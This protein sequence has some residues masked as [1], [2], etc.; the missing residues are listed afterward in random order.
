MVSVHLIVD[1]DIIP[2]P[3]VYYLQMIIRVVYVYAQ[4][5]QA[6]EGMVTRGR[7]M[8]NDFVPLASFPF[9]P[10]PFSPESITDPENVS[11][12]RSETTT[13]TPWH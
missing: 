12:E 9:Y 7:W 11:K 1:T 2:R 6:A 8:N 3:R 4:N 5:K 10:L 13:G